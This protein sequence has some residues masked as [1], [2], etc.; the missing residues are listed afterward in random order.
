MSTIGARSTIHATRVL[1]FLATLF[2]VM[3]PIVTSAEAPAA[4]PAAPAQ[5]AP[6]I[7][8]NPIGI[9]DPR[10]LIGRVIGVSL[11]IVGSIALLVFM[12]GGLMWMTSVGNPER[13]S[14]GKM[15]ILWA[16]I[17]LAVIFTSYALVS[18][19]LNAL[20]PTGGQ[21]GQTGPNSVQVG[22]NP[23]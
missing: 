1:L 4:P 13:V 23:Q 15:T 9:N 21:T 14:K 19:T 20:K 3:L 16:A 7:L 11:G 6:V 22:P 12:W 5:T 10:D 18:F 2:F 17:G 8:H